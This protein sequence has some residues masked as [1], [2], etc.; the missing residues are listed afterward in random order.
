MTDGASLFLARRVRVY[1]RIAVVVYAFVV[2]W[3]VGFSH[4]GVDSLGKPLGYDFIAYWGTSHLTLQG[5]PAAAFDDSRLAVAEQIAVPSIQ[6][7]YEWRYPP[8]YQ[9]L[10]TPLALLPYAAAL[11]LFVGTTL[12][13][14]L[15]TVRRLLELPHPM[16]IL[17]ALPSTFICAVQGQNSFL[18]AAL[19]AGGILLLPKRPIFGGI[20]L[21]L[22]AFKPQYGL[23][24]PFALIA[25]QQWR[26]FAAATVA[27]AVYIGVTIAVFGIDLWQAFFANLSIVRQMMED[28][29]MPWPKMPSLFIFLRLLGAATPLAYFAQALAAITALGAV[30]YIWRRCGP[31]ALAGAV[32]VSAALISVNYIFDYAFVIQSVPLAILASDM[33][34]RGA[35]TWEKR[36]LVMLAIAPALMTFAADWIGLQIGFLALAFTLFLSVHRAVRPEGQSAIAR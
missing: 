23:L 25:G 3:L 10:I 19:F 21:A 12:I 15:L 27:L 13:I 26:A 35:A 36:A 29:L 16:L 2:L 28:H 5:Q 30:V 20:L 32:L 1:P 34:R 9:L 33:T 8:T 17:L 6:F 11:S 14:Y 7:V 4:N 18:T 31:T 22:I 24:I